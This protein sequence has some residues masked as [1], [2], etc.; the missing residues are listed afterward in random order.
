[1]S[2]QRRQPKKTNIDDLV[3]RI[4]MRIAA[5]HYPYWIHEEH[6]ARALGVR[7]GHV[8]QAMHRLN[9]E[10]VVTQ[11]SGPTRKFGFRDRPRRYHVRRAVR[12]DS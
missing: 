9:L 5:G 2:L 12:P 11:R 3:L 8:R 7:T 4:K 1:M 6:L 10:G